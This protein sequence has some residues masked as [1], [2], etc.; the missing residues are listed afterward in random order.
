MRI[1]IIEDNKTIAENIKRMAES[2]KLNAAVC[3]TAQDGLYLSETEDFDV[4]VLDWMLPDYSGIELCRK[5]RG[6]NN[7]TPI[8]MLTAKGQLED[9]IEGL[10]TGADDFLT[11]P[12]AMQELLVRLK[13]LMRRKSGASQSPI[14]KINTLRVN[15]NTCEVSCT[16]KIIRLA[17]K[18]YAVLEYLAHNKNRVIGRIDILNH[19]WGNEIDIFSNTVDV[20][21]RYLRKKIELPFKTKFIKTII[22]KGYMLCGN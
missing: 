9:K 8:L 5:L 2:V 10:E 16:G 19:V 20:H 15:T 22:N 21:I 11:K 14:I 17:P 3:F 13:A 7:P 4:I 18:E 6:N 1:L 12:F